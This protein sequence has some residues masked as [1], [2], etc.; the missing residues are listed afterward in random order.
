MMKVLW[1]TSWYPNKLDSMNGDFIQRHARA[2]SLFCDVHVIHLEPDR[3][4][5]LYKKTETSVSKQDNLTEEIVLY[6]LSA[7]PYAAKYFSYRRYIT[8]FKKCIKA[9]IE[10]YGKPA[11]VHVQ[12]PM[13]AGIL[14]LWVKKKYGIAYIV[15]EHWAIY[16]DIAPDAFKK[17]NFFFRSFTK[18]I[19]QQA[20]MFT[21][22]SA[23]LGKAVQQLV[24]PVPFTPVANVA[25]TCIFTFRKQ[26]N[27]HNENFVFLHV[28]TLKHQK[29]PEGIIKAYSEFLKTHPDALLVMV[30]GENDTFKTYAASLN[31]P[32]Q[33]T[34]FT[35]F[36]SYSEV[37]E[38][39]H[40]SDALLMFSRYENL[41]CVIIE[42][43]CSGLPVISTDVGG[44]S[45]L[46]NKSNG[47]LIQSED[48]SALLQAMLYM[49]NNKQ[50]FDG[51]L[52][53]KNAVMLFSYRVIGKRIYDIYISTL[54]NN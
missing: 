38:W 23:A 30:G 3:Q 37:A 49:Y 25:D 44:V 42:A 15:T 20:A 52:I 28:S 51:E 47:L 46:L 17:R 5:V 6:K 18:R 50:K 36:V 31:I 32:V 35:G 9:Y 16:N 12:V 13:K 54:A 41:P 11:I 48:E 40:K 29:N 53:A 2:T 7:V 43:L 1:L 22:V 33:N 39:M 21:P 34:L 26:K 24:A 14:A 8:I 19:L 4:N 27:P 10:Q 45:E